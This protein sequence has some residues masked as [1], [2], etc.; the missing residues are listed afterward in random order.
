[1]RKYFALLL[2]FVAFTF[3][4]CSIGKRLD[5]TAW[6]YVDTSGFTDSYSTS[7]DKYLDESAGDIYLSEFL[8]ELK[9]SL[10]A[11]NIEVISAGTTHQDNN[12]IYFIEI[13]RLEFVEDY[14]TES[15]YMDSTDYE[16][17]TFNV[18][19]CEVSA[20]SILYMLDKGGHKVHVK[21]YSKTVGKDEKL[22]NNR[23]FWQIIF[24]ANKDNSQYTYRELGEDVFIDLSRKAARQTSAGI[25]RQLNKLQ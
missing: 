2:A 6:I 13:K 10:S 25:S 22:S 1:M 4:S 5:N 21:D 12:S 3:S 16:P 14:E 9:S 18:V 7:S 24:G 17:T 11:Y 23:T 15:V 20:K 19:S 8:D